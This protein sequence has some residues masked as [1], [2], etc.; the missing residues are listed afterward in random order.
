MKAIEETYHDVEKM[1]Y[2][3][4]WK[5]V[6]KFGG[7]FDEYLSAANLGFM[8]AYNGYDSSRQC[9]FNTLLWWCVRN[10][11]TDVGRETVKAKRVGLLGEKDG[12]QIHSN[13][14][15]LSQFLASI[16]D[17]ARL[18]VQSVVSMPGDLNLLA[19][20]KRST[21]RRGLSS[22]LQESGWSAARIIE[23]RQEV[24]EAL[25]LVEA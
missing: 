16:S 17:D 6:E 7:E 18:M 4:C 3:L 14:F 24:R 15:D 12:E 13:R 2:Q 1:L 11:I 20:R 10:C 19:G 9:C 23:T 21:V 5:A 25:E 22:M 8:K